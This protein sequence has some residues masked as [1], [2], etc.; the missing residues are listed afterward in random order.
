MT[1][2]TVATLCSIVGAGSLINFFVQRHFSR[3]DEATRQEIKR[4]Q[5]EQAER[6]RKRKEREE[7]HDREYAELHKQVKLGLTTI[8]LL[9]YARVAEE[10]DRLITKGF[11]TPQERK[12][13]SDLHENY[14]AWEWNGDMDGR[15]QRVW[16]LPTEPPITKN[17][18]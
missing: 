14:H 10:A 8:K 4:Q 3:R 12:Y 15:M 6:D 5:A 9:S 1:L 7:R 2:E 18:R 11:A 17:L 13:L 16:E